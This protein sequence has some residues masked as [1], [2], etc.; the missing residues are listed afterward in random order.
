[1]IGNMYANTSFGRGVLPPK[2]TVQTSIASA[3]VLFGVRYEGERSAHATIVDGALTLTMLFCFNDAGLMAS[4]RAE[5]RGASVGKDGL[6]VMLPWDCSLSDYRKQDGM[7]IPMTGE[8]AWIRS[9]GRKAYSHGCVR[10]L[11]Y[12]LSPV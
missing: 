3:A 8:A 12:E 9:V 4:V 6:M 7:L 2:K 1:M 5:A 10:K 11:R